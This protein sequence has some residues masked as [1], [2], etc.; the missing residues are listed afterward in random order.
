METRFITSPRTCT[1]TA[2]KVVIAVVLAAVFG[3]LIWIVPM[4]AKM[5]Q[6]F[7]FNMNRPLEIFIAV[8]NFMRHR[9]WIFWPS[10]IAVLM[11]AKI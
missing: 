5:Y 4:V 11:F 7:P 1:V 6:D 10:A 2:L 9:W 3:A 8:S